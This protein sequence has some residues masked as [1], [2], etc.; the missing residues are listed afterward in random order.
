MKVGY[1]TVDQNIIMRRA[2]L[3]RGLHFISAAVHAELRHGIDFDTRIDRIHLAAQTNIHRDTG[4]HFDR[5]GGHTG[6]RRSTGTRQAPGTIGRILLRVAGRVPVVEHGEGRDA[7][8]QTL[9]AGEYFNCDADNLRG[10]LGV[11]DNFARRELVASVNNGGLAVH[12]WRHH[13]GDGGGIARRKDK[14]DFRRVRTLD[15]ALNI[16]KKIIDG[17]RLTSSN[18]V[19][20]LLTTPLETLQEGARL[21]QEN[22]CGNK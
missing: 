10:R 4:L 19:N 22:F 20:F 18:D 12:T 11:D 2:L 6:V 3:R 16:A 5:N 21:I 1:S 17:E 8:Y 14:K 7:E 15:T 13:E 9:L